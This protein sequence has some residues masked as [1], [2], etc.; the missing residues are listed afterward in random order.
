MWRKFALAATIS[1]LFPVAAKADDVGLFFRIP[2]DIAAPVVNKTATIDPSDGAFKIY[3]STGWQ[4]KTLPQANLA[5]TTAPTINDDSGDGYAIGSFW[6]DNVGAQFYVCTDAT[7]GSAT[8]SL[9]TSGTVSPTDLTNAV[10]TKLTTADIFSDFKV[11]GFA[12]SDPGASLAMTT[13]LGIAYV[14]GIR[15]EFSATPYTYTASKDTYDYLQS[16]GTTNHI[17]VNN[18]ASAPSGQPGLLLQ[19]V[20]T[21]GTEITSVTTLAPSAP[22]ISVGDAVGDGDALTLGQANLLY[23]PISL[24]TSKTQSYVYRVSDSGDGAPAFGLLTNGHLPVVDASHGGMGTAITLNTLGLFY[25]TGTTGGLT[26]EPAANQLPILNSG[27][28]AWSYITKADLIAEAV[29]AAVDEIGE[30]GGGSDE[31]FFGGGGS[32]GGLTLNT[33]SF[34]NPEITDNTTVE[35]P[36][37]QTVDYESGTVINATETITITGTVNVA[38]SAE[39]GN[40]T[41][42]Q[43]SMEP[44][45]GINGG[46]VGRVYDCVAGGGGGGCGGKGGSGGS[47]TS[48]VVGGVGG[49]AYDKSIVTNVRGLTG[50]GG[51]AGE[52]D[53]GAGGDGGKGGGFIGFHAKGAIVVDG[54]INCAGEDGAAGTT[55]AGGGGGGS[56]GVVEFSSQT[57][58]DLSAATINLAGGDGGDGATATDGGGG[59]GAGGVLVLISPSTITFGGTIT[60]TGGGAG[61]NGTQTGT[62]GGTG[63]ILQ[64]T[65]KP[66]EPI[67]LMQGGGGA[68]LLEWARTEYLASGNRIIKWDREKTEHMLAI[69]KTLDALSIN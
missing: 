9:I 20:I 66:N 51:S 48:S 13:P 28:S 63:F 46:H 19:K 12:S 50:S 60:L 65:I 42:A 35:I 59:G 69:V 17:A 37:G 30:G 61:A 68:F 6:F 32:Q 36:T 40:G 8:W 7:L 18:E 33:S 14:D 25:S 11:S 52:A 22:S 58:I 26:G 44:G 64:L 3:A 41:S 5:A 15:V 54:V 1:L 57:S 16:N 2:S 34:S 53:S 43:S 67:N 21:D 27:G 4:N 38:Y 49:G 29:A 55:G 10:K 23:A 24:T 39:G 31:S 56:G 47:D 45:A 62:S